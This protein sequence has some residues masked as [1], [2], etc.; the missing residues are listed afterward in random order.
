MSREGENEMRKI[1]VGC[2]VTF[3]KYPFRILYFS[4]VF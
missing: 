4:N 2:L 3:I 1:V